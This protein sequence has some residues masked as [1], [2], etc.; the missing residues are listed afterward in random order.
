[1]TA[2]RARAG[3]AS[4]ALSFFF[5]NLPKAD[6]I[7]QRLHPRSGFHPQSGFH[8]RAS[9]LPMRRSA[10]HAEGNS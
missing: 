1:M 2:K 7:A 8:C 6:F 5:L 3:T 4:L 10:I 9:A